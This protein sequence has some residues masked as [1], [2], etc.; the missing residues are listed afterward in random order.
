[1]KPEIGSKVFVVAGGYCVAAMT[2]GFLG[3]DSFL[4]KHYQMLSQPELRYDREGEDWFASREAAEE[5]AK[6]LKM[7]HFL[8]E[9]E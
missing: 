6:R 8:E 2:V 4:L 9:S 7:E 1:M 3:E 5:E